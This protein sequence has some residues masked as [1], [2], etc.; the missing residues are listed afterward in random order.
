VREELLAFIR[1]EM[2]EAMLRRR[3]ILEDGGL[4]E[5][6]TGPATRV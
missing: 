1:N 5:I 2:P 4:R 3:T 6:D